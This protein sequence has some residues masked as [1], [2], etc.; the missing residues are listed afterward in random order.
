MKKRFLAG[1][2]CG[3]MMLGLAGL[4][5]ATPVAE[6]GGPYGGSYYATPGSNLTLV[7]A[8]SYDTDP[9]ASIDSYL[10]DLN[11]DGTYESGGMTVLFSVPN[12]PLGYQYW[13]HLK[14]IDSLGAFGIDDAF[15]NVVDVLPPLPPPPPP[16]DAPVPEPSTMLL[17]GG[18]LAGLGLISRR[19]KNRV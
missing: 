9:N 13:V 7:G 6:A 2:A 3:V 14:V 10:W 18:G 5:Q 8:L 1:L 16:P 15:I 12:V 17:L 19:R 4:A 11:N